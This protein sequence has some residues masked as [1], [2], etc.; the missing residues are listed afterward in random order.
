MCLQEH[1]LVDD[2]FFISF[3]LSY[4]LHLQK[5]KSAQACWMVYTDFSLA[6]F[7]SHHQLLFTMSSY[8]AAELQT[9]IDDLDVVLWKAITDNNLKEVFTV[10]KSRIVSV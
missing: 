9:F 1:M 8:S 5:S 3:F 7:I 4:Q 2:H 10:E 6:F